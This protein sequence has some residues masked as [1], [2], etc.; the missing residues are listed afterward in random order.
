MR[1]EHRKHDRDS[2]RRIYGRWEDDQAPLQD[3][4]EALGN[5]SAVGKFL[6]APRVP[7]IAGQLQRSSGVVAVLAAVLTVLWCVAVTCRMF[8]LMFFSHGLRFLHTGCS[9]RVATRGHVNG[10]VW[11]GQW[12]AVRTR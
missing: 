3:E 2:G 1:C 8:A 10:R 4:I 5:S 9:T 11:P 6:R 7:A 12:V